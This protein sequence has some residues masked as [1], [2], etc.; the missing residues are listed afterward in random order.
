MKKRIIAGL[1][2]STLAVSTGV[3]GC[4]QKSEVSDVI[5]LGATFT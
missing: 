4:S 2:A 1:L 3:M 5:Q